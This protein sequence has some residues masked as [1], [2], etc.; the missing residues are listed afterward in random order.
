MF[1]KGYLLERGA[2][3]EILTNKNR[4][5]RKIGKDDYIASSKIDDSSE[6]ESTSEIALSQKYR[7]AGHL[8]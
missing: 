7:I 2:Y 4:R 3:F 6:T 8:N 5:L 1:S